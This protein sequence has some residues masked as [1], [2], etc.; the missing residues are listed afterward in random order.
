MVTPGRGLPIHDAPRSGAMHQRLLTDINNNDDVAA[1]NTLYA[2][3]NECQAQRGRQLT[4]E[5][6]D[7]LIQQ[8]NYIIAFLQQE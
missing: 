7:L 2:F 6:A 5:Q 4:N 1:I 8:A 3:I